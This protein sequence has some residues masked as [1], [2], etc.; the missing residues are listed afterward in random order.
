MTTRTP[1][2]Y[3]LE[4]AE[5]MASAAERLIEAVNELAA[6]QL[7][8]AESDDVPSDDEYDVKLSVDE[9]LRTLRSRIY[10]F[11]KRRDRASNAA[12]QSAW[13]GVDE[14]L[15]E[16]VY[17]DDTPCVIHGDAIP[18]TLYSATVL[19]ALKGGGVRTDNLTTIE[20]KSQGWWHTYGHRVV[21]WMPTPPAPTP[22]GES[23]GP[24]L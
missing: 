24:A 11:R 13:I 21:A 8:I 17:R 22:K 1:Q 7:R 12:P 18:P 15:P 23:N 2:N 9:R 16:W 4:H 20:G 10:E 19:V 3:A 5:Y 6:M 14:R